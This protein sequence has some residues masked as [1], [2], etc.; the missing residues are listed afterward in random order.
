MPE[1][2]CHETE[3]DSAIQDKDKAG[4]LQGGGW[5]DGRE[6]VYIEWLHYSNISQWALVI[7]SWGMG[8]GLFIMVL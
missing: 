7:G 5:D 2:G 3:D 8:A 1:T 6:E 4:I